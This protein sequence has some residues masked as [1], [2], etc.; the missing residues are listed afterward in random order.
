VEVARL[1]SSFEIDASAE[2]PTF[3]VEGI[4]HLASRMLLRHEHGVEI[5][6]SRLDKLVGWHFGESESS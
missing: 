1:A 6:E 2:R 5:P 4:L 3:D